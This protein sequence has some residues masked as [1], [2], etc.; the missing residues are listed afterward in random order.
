MTEHSNIT[1]FYGCKINAARLQ[2][3]MWF[4]FSF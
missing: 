4:I 1:T 2:F 3:V